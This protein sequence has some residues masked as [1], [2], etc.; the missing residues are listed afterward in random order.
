MAQRG[1]DSP[2]MVGPPV[3]QALL[4]TPV[5]QARAEFHVL[6]LP[7]GS[8]D[9]RD[10]PLADQR[11][12]GLRE[13]EFPSAPRAFLHIVPNITPAIADALDIGIATAIAGAARSSSVLMHI[14][15]G[16]AIP[17]PM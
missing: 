5:S 14:R 12:R 3:T 7:T 17:I 4:G 8:V 9:L 10:H 1:V 16:P 2:Y 13:V 11:R 15:D 6:R